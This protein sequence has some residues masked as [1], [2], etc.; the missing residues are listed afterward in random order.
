MPIS[1]CAKA[2]QLNPA[3]SRTSGDDG[4]NEAGS[5]KGFELYPERSVAK[6]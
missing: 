4:K 3:C 1:Q 2:N 6:S 5:G